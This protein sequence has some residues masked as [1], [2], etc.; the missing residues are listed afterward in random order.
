MIFPRHARRDKP[1]WAYP[2]WAV[3]LPEALLVG[4]LWLVDHNHVR[5]PS[6]IA[7]ILT[8]VPLSSHN[9]L[10]IWLQGSF[11]ALI[12]S[13]I[14]PVFSTNSYIPEMLL[15]VYTALAFLLGVYLQVW[16]IGVEIGLG[17]I[18]FSGRATLVA[19]LSLLLRRLL[20]QWRLG[21]RNDFPAT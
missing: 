18:A 4:F 7:T 12:I 13:M 16:G 17:L 11:L 15:L 20:L 8:F 21:K 1:F 19:G 5:P 6:M 9:N 14:V 3:P 10:W 2:F